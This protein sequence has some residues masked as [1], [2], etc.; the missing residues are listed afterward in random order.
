LV[1]KT[2]LFYDLQEIKNYKNQTDKAI[3]AKE[4]TCNREDPANKRNLGKNSENQSDYKACYY[5]DYDSDYE[6]IGCR[7]SE[8]ERE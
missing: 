1:Y 2:D 7:L 5:I 4:R 8:G 6:V 3:Q